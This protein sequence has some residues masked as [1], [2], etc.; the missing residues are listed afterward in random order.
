MN[1]KNLD[2]FKLANYIAGPA[3]II[4]GFLGFVPAVTPNGM[5]FGVFMVD[6]FHNCVHIT[7]GFILLIAGLKPNRLMIIVTFLIGFA[8]LALAIFGFF[9]PASG[10]MFNFSDNLLHLAIS[11]FSLFQ[12]WIITKVSE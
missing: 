3:L 10:G 6:G 2:F 12:G 11:L 7:T 8:F 1:E 5:V 9:V 4:L